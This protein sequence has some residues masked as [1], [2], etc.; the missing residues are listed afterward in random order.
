MPSNGIIRSFAFFCP[1][2]QRGL[3]VVPPHGERRGSSRARHGPGRR[4][5]EL[6]HLARLQRTAPCR[7]HPRGRLRRRHGNRIRKL[8]RPPKRKLPF[9]LFRRARQIPV[10]VPDRAAHARRRRHRPFEDLR[11]DRKNPTGLFLRSSKSSPLRTGRPTPERRKRAGR[12]S[13]SFVPP[14]PANMPTTPR[15]YS[16]PSG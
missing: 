9:L 13:R 11:S 10:R 16:P 3:R 6:P 2:R 14:R 7:R 15:S 4:S 8:H 12:P 1:D 5:G